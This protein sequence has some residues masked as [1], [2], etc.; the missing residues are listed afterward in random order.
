MPV[1]TFVL[2]P[3]SEADTVYSP[4]G[5]SG[6][7]YSPVSAVTTTRLAAVPEFVTFTSTPGMMAPAESLTLPTI[8]ALNDCPAAWLQQAMIKIKTPTLRLIDVLPPFFANV[9]FGGLCFSDSQ[10][11]SWCSFSWPYCE[12][13]DMVGQQP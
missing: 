9:L 1:R 11:S 7:A 8:V 13:P 2:N 4:G 5:S 3:G 10:H 12:P 6:T